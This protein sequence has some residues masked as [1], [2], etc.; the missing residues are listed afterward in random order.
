M[1]FFSFSF[2]IFF[3]FV[4]TSRRRRSTSSP[5]MHE[6][7]TCSGTVWLRLDNV[8]VGNGQL[9]VNRLFEC[10]V[11]L[12]RLRIPTPLALPRHTLSSRNSVSPV[13][14]VSDRFLC[15]FSNKIFFLY[16]YIRLIPWFWDRNIRCRLQP[17]GR[18]FG[19]LINFW[20]K[21]GGR[22]R[23][24]RGGREDIQTKRRN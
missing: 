7:W 17:S 23:Q 8:P 6:T 11:G 20:S 18:G 9:P 5:T 10:S 2:F 3:F 15:V 4:L 19:F 12:H 21:T 1:R 24:F 22:G 13:T 14:R 16:I